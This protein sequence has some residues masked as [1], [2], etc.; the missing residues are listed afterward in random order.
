MVSKRIRINQK[1]IY[2][3]L[4]N[5]IL[6]HVPAPKVEIDKPFAMLSTL[7]YADSFLGR[8]LVGRVGQGTARRKSKCQSN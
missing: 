8:C 5:L 1:K 7:L 4:L 6:E 3:L 2:T